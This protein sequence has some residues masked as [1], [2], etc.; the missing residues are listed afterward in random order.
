M[1]HLGDATPLCMQAKH[2]RND[3]SNRK[4]LRSTVIDAR[5]GAVS[6]SRRRAE[7][8]LSVSQTLQSVSQS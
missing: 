3:T 1:S 6:R 5:C 4:A 8:S 7:L 2:N